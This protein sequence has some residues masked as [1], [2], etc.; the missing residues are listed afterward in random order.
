MIPYNAD[1]VR[2]FKAKYLDSLEVREFDPEV[3]FIFAEL[4]SNWIK[5]IRSLIKMRSEI[6]SS[7]T[8]KQIE[9]LVKEDLVLQSKPR[10]ARKFH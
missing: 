5:L 3:E 10:E 4:M 6:S 8:R 9:Q 1:V 2:E 7:V